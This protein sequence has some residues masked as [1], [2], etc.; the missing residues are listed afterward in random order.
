MNNSIEKYLIFIAVLNLILLAGCK[1]EKVPVVT[2]NDSITNVTES[3][4]TSG[5]KITDDGGAAV[6]ARGVCWSISDA[7]STTD[8]KTTDGS[9]SGSFSSNITGLSGGETYFIR[10]YATN[11]AGTGYGLAILF[12]TP[13]Q[14]P[15]PPIAITLPA[16]S[17]SKV[18]GAYLATLCG[19]VY[20]NYSITSYTFEYGTTETYEI[21]TLSSGSVN[22]GT[23][24][25]VQYTTGGFQM[26]TLYH[27]RV[28]AWNSYGIAYGDDMTFTTVSK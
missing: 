20:A 25:F 15:G 13:S 24:T 28:K 9:G 17:V 6:K 5:G 10:A 11:S 16:Q 14:S 21:G 8:S 18:T 23:Y 3:T 19:S 27:Y 12:K 22:G 4:A 7:P 2:T 26:S 1:K